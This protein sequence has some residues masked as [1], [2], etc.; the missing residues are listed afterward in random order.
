M[1][2]SGSLY[3]ERRTVFHRLDGSIKLIMLVA[4]TAFVFAFMD[5][6]VFAVILLCGF[7]MLKISKLPAKN[8]CPLFVFIL[9]FTVFNSAFLLIITPQYGSKMAGV[10]TELINIGDF[11]IIT[12]ETLFYCLTLSLKYICILPIT[13]LFIFTTH[14]SDFSSSLNRIGV[15]YRVAY[16]VNIALRYIPDVRDEVDHI[17]SA[18][19]AKGVAFK[20]GDAGLMTRLK[21]YGTLMVPLLLSSLNRIEVI[22][23]AMDLRGFGKNKRRTWYHRK[24]ITL[25]DVAF[26][27]ISVVVLIA[28]IGIKVTVGATFWYPF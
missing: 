20:K 15:S 17:I 23:N 12:A 25:V 8:I 14:P 10:Y 13:I 7:V 11:Y 26:L 5:I 1:S 22:S 4:W 24:R 27:V 2:K 18:Q 19:E 21:N 6:R 16:A 9:I 28:G 3:V